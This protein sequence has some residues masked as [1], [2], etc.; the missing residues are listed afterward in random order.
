MLEEDDE[1]AGEGG[2]AWICSACGYIHD[3]D[4]PP[5]R[6]PVC[7]VG[8]DCFALHVDIE[9]EDDVVLEDADVDD[10]DET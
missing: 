2:M 7:A 10:D 5:D 3:G 9:D 1:M 8:A 6:C 4:A